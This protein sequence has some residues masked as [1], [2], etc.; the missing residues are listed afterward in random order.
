MKKFFFLGI[1]LVLAG[2]LLVS[3]QPV[4]AHTQAQSMK[5]TSGGGC[6]ATTYLTVCISEN[7]SGYIMP[8]IYV[9]TT[10]ACDITLW[11][12]FDTFGSDAQTVT[13]GSCYGVGSH[14]YGTI[15]MAQS[16]NF[17]L[18]AGAQAKGVGWNE[19]DSPTLYTWAVSPGG[20]S[21]IY[22]GG[23]TG[24]GYISACISDA[25]VNLGVQK[26]L[27]DAYVYGSPCNVNVKIY[28]NGYPF[29]GNYYAGCYSSGTH[30]YGA[31]VWANNG[32]SWQ[33]YAQEYSNGISYSEWSP[34]QHD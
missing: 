12:T 20:Q 10:T 19:I 17:Q 4:S 15:M 27:P 31:T 22:G 32:Q 33:T 23:C 28:D 9:N 8:D 14:L 6:T 18:T 5:A 16:G 13:Y 2:A 1:L 25:G 26:I 34:V 3:P 29:A 11:L 7:S 24:N 30:L 21:P